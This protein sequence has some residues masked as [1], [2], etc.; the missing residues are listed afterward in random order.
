MTNLT[1]KV[2]KQHT[3]PKFLLKNI[4]LGKKEDN[5]KLFTFDKKKEKIFQ[6]SV[7]DA[8][9]RNSFYNFVDTPQQ[10]SL[11]SYLS[12]IESEA[13]III[14]NIIKSKSLSNLDSE[15]RETLSIFVLTQYFRTYGHLKL[16]ESMIEKI[17]DKIRD[18]GFDPKDAKNLEYG[19]TTKLKNS[20]LLGILNAIENSIY[21]SEKNWHLFETDEENPFLISDHPVV[22]N[23]EYNF[24]LYGNLGLGVKGVQVFLPIS[25]TLLLAMFCPSYLIDLYKTKENAIWLSQNTILEDKLINNINLILKN[26]E[27][28]T[29]T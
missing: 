4:G 17:A 1:T 8:T 19:N 22:L 29:K 16:Q 6:Q 28:F 9:T 25:S 7:N 23:N 26:I 15:K 12:E 5:K 18:M 13:A 2:K 10:L 11:E 21:I 20:F 14:Q 24:G 27:N 3:V